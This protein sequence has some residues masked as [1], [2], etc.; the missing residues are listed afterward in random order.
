MIFT[1]P[2]DEYFDYRFGKLPYRSLAVRVRDARNRS[3]AQPVAVIN[4]PNEHAYTRVTEFKHLTGQE[5]P[6][7]PGLR[8]PAAPSGDPYY[9]I[10]RPEN[11]SPVQALQALADE[12]P[13]V[14]FVG[15]L[16]TYRYYNMDQ[17]V[18]QALTLRSADRRAL[19]APPAAMPRAS[20]RSPGS[21]TAAR[22]APARARGRCNAPG[23][24]QSSAAKRP[25]RDQPRQREVA[26]PDVP[27]QTAA[28]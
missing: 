11:A 5:H 21:V 8:V 6:R 12:T 3:Q 16:A 14:H 26:H 22:S 18:A 19:P 25:A 13:G 4:Y 7:R 20:R 15:R 1:G 27:H 23:S 28:H 2:V 17:V 10:P 24:L 9:P